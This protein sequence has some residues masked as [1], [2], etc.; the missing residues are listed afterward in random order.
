MWFIYDY[1]VQ[2][3]VVP[4]KYLHTKHAE[5]SFALKMWS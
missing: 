2:A 5:Q 1:V 3:I 4:T